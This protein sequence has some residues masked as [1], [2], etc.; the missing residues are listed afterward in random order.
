MFLELRC[1]WIQGFLLSS[2][3]E[4]VCF[5]KAQLEKSMFFP[6]NLKSDWLLFQ[7]PHHVGLESSFHVTADILKES[8]VPLNFQGRL[9]LQASQVKCHSIKLLEEKNCSWKAETSNKLRNVWSQFKMAGQ[10]LN[11]PSPPKER[12]TGINHSWQSTLIFEFVLTLVGPARW[13]GT[14]AERLGHQGNLAS[15]HIWE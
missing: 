10:N 4:K 6:L 9:A 15:F 5:G 1:T 7:N 2:L 3:V 11:K 14:V 8:Q 13:H 12:Q